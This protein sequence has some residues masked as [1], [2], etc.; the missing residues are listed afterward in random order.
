VAAPVLLFAACGGDDDGNGAVTGGTTGGQ[1][2]V[3][4]A[5]PGGASA[6]APGSTAAGG[7]GQ[8]TGSGAAALQRLARDISGKTYQVTYTI[9]FTTDGVAESGT[10]IIANKPPKS[11]YVFDVDGMEMQIINDGE[12]TYL[13]SDEGGS[14]QCLKTRTGVGISAL[15]ANPFDLQAIL[16]EF[17]EDVEVTATRDERV[18]GIDSECFTVKNSEGESIACFSKADGLLTKVEGGDGAD[19]MKVMATG[20]SSNVDDR[21]LEP[22]AGYAIMDLGQ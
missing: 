19:A 21:L 1:S 18:G 4:T 2:T 5:T 9:E 11:A 7:T 12:F 22:P 6:P 3:A 17:E 10:M 14:G 16:S 20:M 13:C 15:A 8:V